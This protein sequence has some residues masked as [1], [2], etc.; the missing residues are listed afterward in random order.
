MNNYNIFVKYLFSRIDSSEHLVNL[1]SQP[2]F[3][4]FQLSL[5]QLLQLLLVLLDLSSE[6]VLHKIP[7]FSGFHELVLNIV[8]LNVEVSNNS[9]FV[10]MLFLIELVLNNDHS[11]K[12]HNCSKCKFQTMVV[13]NITILEMSLF[14]I[15]VVPKFSCYRYE[16]FSNNK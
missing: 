6:C 4:F 5:H 3:G 9:C 15:R 7:F 10:V 13:L 11:K 2:F 14:W 12:K 16:L 1:A 8:I